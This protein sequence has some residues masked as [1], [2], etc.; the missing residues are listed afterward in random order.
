MLRMFSVNLRTII[1]ANGKSVTTLLRRI[2][3]NKE[4]RVAK[5]EWAANGILGRFII[6]KVCLILSLAVRS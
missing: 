2:R 5:F 3:P 1:A 6:R 4:D